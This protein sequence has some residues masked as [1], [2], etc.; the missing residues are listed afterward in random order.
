MKIN[1]K[2]LV[3]ALL[4][5]TACNNNA[6]EAAISKSVDTSMARK[7]AAED[8]YKNVVFDDKYDLIC[9]MPVTAGVSDTAH[10]RN[11]IYGFCSPEC[12]A[13]FIKSPLAA[14]NSKK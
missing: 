10:Y 9:G 12:K 13:E 8:L 2:M 3:F 14:L 11:K 4:C 6:K 1:T 7:P 5:F